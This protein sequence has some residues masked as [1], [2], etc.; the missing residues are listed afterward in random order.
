MVKGL[1]E[2]LQLVSQIS[3]NVDGV[4]RAITVKTSTQLKMSLVISVRKEDILVHNFFQRTATQ[5]SVDTADSLDATHSIADTTTFPPRYSMDTYNQQ[6]INFKSDAGAEV[7][8][9]SQR[10]YESL[11][12]VKL[13]RYS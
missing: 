12:N 3:N 10:V 7:T 4:E 11:P 13:Q 1:T 8:A 2:M 6:Q 5:H 9:I